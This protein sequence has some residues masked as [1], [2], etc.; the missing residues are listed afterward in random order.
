MSFSPNYAMPSEV[1]VKTGSGI[2]AVPK[3]VCGKKVVWLYSNRITKLENFP[4]TIV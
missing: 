1:Y 2:A 3:D 4:D